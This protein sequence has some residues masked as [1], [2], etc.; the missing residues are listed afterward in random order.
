MIPRPLDSTENELLA[1]LDNALQEGVFSEHFLAE[2]RKIL[3][4]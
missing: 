4:P 3:G 2:L 1:L